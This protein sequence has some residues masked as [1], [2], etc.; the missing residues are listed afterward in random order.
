MKK[1]WLFVPLLVAALVL[2][3]TGGTVLAQGGGTSGDSP[4]KSF[5][6]RVAAIL[7]LD[8]AKVQSA[9]N[10]AAKEMQDEALQ[11]KLDRMVEQGRLTKEQADQTKQWYQSRPEA[12]SPGSPFGGH[13]FFRGPMWGGRGWHGMGFKGGTPPAPKVTPKDSGATSF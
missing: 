13:G 8:E 11:Q 7:G 6:T 3:I 1:R 12:L 4:L 5:A 10:Q 2:G 9:F